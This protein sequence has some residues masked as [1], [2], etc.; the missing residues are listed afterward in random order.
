MS[1]VDPKSTVITVPRDTMF[2]V[3]QI[4]EYFKHQEADEKIQKML[5]TKEIKDYFDYRLVGNFKDFLEEK[6]VAK[7]RTLEF[8]DQEKKIVRYILNQEALMRDVRVNIEIKVLQKNFPTV[9]IEKACEELSKDDICDIIY[10]IEEE[11]DEIFTMLGNAPSYISDIMKKDEKDNNSVRTSI[12][13]L[14]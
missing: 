8:N 1:L 11:I 3:E 5:E 12:I 9:N 13:L 10:N 14:K 4:E 7:D 2:T 6:F